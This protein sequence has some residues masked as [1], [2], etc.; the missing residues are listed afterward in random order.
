MYNT[1]NSDLT[2]FWIILGYIKFRFDQFLDYEGFIFHSF[3]CIRLKKTL[4]KTCP[5]NFYFQTM[6]REYSKY[7]SVFIETT[8]KL[9]N[10]VTR[11]KFAHNLNIHY[12]KVCPI[13]SIV[14]S[15]W[16]ETFSGYT[17]TCFP[18]LP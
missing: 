5:N 12:C 14:I 17:C 2:D 16:S 15:I 9:S 10:H 18:I 8:N 6:Q 1:Y 4:K 7:S 11:F 3:N 13:E